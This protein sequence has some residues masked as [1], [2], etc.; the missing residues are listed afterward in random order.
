MNLSVA[1]GPDQRSVQIRGDYNLTGV[2]TTLNDGIRYNP[3]A[4]QFAVAP[5]HQ[6]VLCVALAI[7]PSRMPVYICTNNWLLAKVLGMMEFRRHDGL[8]CDIEN[9]SSL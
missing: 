6:G 2:S 9:F 7:Q 8:N 5:L 4:Q 1:K 3:T